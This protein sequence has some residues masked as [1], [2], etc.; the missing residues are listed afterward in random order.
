MWR[1]GTVEMFT[2]PTR[3]NTPAES[4]PRAGARG[5]RRRPRRLP[6][7]GRSCAAEY[8]GCPLC[9][10]EYTPPSLR[11][12]CRHSPP[13]DATPAG[14]GRARTRSDALT[15][16]GG[17]LL[18]QR[19]VRPPNGHVAPASGMPACQAP[20]YGGVRGQCMGF[21]RWRQGA[22]KVGLAL[23]VGQDQRYRGSRD[24]PL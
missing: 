2:A 17:P 21:S 14:H 18:G 24:T 22:G 19:T 6:E 13:G 20:A 23:P 8:L 15:G 9:A 5:P 3:A 7:G 11:V 4:W 1:Q 16:V 12:Q 10:G